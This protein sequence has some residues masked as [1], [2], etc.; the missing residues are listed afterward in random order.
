MMESR[1]DLSLMDSRA[2]Q[3]LTSTSTT[4]KGTVDEKTMHDLLITAVMG[5]LREGIAK[6]VVRVKPAVSKR[7]LCIEGI[8]DNDTYQAI[9]SFRSMAGV[10]SVTI[11]ASGST[12]C[13][14]L[15]MFLQ[16]AAE[17]SGGTS[18]RRT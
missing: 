18:F 14:I 10:S 11:F 3:R 4:L 13:H 17:A 15:Q 12:A 5:Q 6:K 9:I 16:D 2:R 7:T 8:R 1:L